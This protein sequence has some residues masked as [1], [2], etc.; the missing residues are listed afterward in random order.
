M[1]SSTKHNLHSTNYK[2]KVFFK[3][4]GQTQLLFSK[5]TIKKS[6]NKRKITFKIIVLT[7]LAKLHLLLI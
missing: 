6:I 1:K 5:N 3:G 2:I 7:S 4:V